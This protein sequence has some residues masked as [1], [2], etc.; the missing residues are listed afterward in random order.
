MSESLPGEETDCSTASD[1]KEVTECPTC[2]RDDFKSNLGMRTHHAKVHGESISMVSVECGNCSEELSVALH[3]Y[4]NHDEFYCSDECKGSGQRKQ[5]TYE[6]DWCNETKSQPESVYSNSERHFCSPE[7]NSK[8]MGENLTGENS[9]SWDPTAYETKECEYCNSEFSHKKSSAS[10]GRF[11]SRVCKDKN[12]S[13]LP[14]EEQP[15]WN[16]GGTT[17]YYGPNWPE[18]RNKIVERDNHTCQGCK[19]HKDDLD[20][21]IDVHHIIPIEEFDSHEDANYWLNL[22]TFCRKCH[23]RWE[24]IPL[25]PL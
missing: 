21:V 13:E 2:G 20:T 15:A 6:C 23:R 10:P 16:G 22:V 11:C 3:R 14:P 25:R 17:V 12:R 5:V 4:D 18:I 7:C 1:D 24:G 19:T 8:W 9:P